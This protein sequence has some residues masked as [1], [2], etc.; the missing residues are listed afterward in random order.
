MRF[1]RILGVIWEMP[2]KIPVARAPFMGAGPAIRPT[3]W[4]VFLPVCYFLQL[5]QNLDSRDDYG[6][7]NS[8]GHFSS[9]S[10]AEVGL[11]QI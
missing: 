7:L 11:T 3:P 4:Q 2:D 8:S 9:W 5:Q 6:T 10:K 1:P